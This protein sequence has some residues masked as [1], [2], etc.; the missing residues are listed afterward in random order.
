MIVA[1]LVGVAAGLG[2]VARYVI[3]QV[4]QHQHDLLFPVGTITVNV[5][6]S[7][8]LGL[9]TGLGMHHGLAPD[10][11][12]VLAAGFCSGF[13]TWSAFAYE[14]LAL[15]ESG[16]LLQAAANIALSVTVGLL[17]AGAGLGLALL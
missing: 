11:G 6:G 10:V 2:A 7:L 12:V 13:T 3:D 5:C 4:V 15:A 17:A 1:V 8:L 16:A 14:T 9:I